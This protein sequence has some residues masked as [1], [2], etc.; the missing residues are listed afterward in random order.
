MEMGGSKKHSQRRIKEMKMSSLARAT[1][2]V[3]MSLAPVLAATG[4]IPGPNPHP[5]PQ[6]AAA[7]VQVVSA[8][9][10]VSLGYVS[11]DLPTV[12]TVTDAQTGAPVQYLSKG[13]FTFTF[14]PVVQ[15]CA[16]PVI[17][18]VS[19]QVPGVY[20]V[21]L[22]HDQNTTLCSWKVAEYPVAV[23]VY[24]VGNEILPFSP[25]SYQGQVSTL[26]TIH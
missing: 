17:K 11:T 12:V 1:M 13:N 22:G 23:Q 5:Q 25:G 2:S 20:N 14:A 15:L 7:D 10:N 26:I 19:S 24:S 21:V 3:V 4:G 18:S 8:G 6:L 16:A 9:N